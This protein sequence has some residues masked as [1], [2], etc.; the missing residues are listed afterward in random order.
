[1]FSKEGLGGGIHPV[2]PVT[3]LGDVEVHLKDAPLWPE[4]LE[5]DGE[6]GFEPL[7]DIASTLPQEEVPGDL[8]RV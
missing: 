5:E 3:K 2:G 1:M 4:E 6:V 7:A 8:L